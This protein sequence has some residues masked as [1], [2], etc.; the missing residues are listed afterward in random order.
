MNRTRLKTSDRVWP[1]LRSVFASGLL[2]LSSCHDVSEQNSGTETTET[3]GSFQSDT[4]S[5]ARARQQMVDRHLA[6]RDIHH[7]RVLEAMAR[8]P[9]HQFVPKALQAVAY[10]DSPL[11]IDAGQT[12]SQPYIVALMTQL[13]DPKADHKALD[14]GTGSG[15]QAA[16][17]SE[18]VDE[19][20]SIE[21]VESLADEARERLR[22]L[23]YENVTVRSGDGYAGWESEAPFDL[24]IV[25]AAPDHVPPALV[26]QLAVG[27]KLVIP[28]GDRVQNL[29]VIEKKPDG[30]IVKQEVAPVA[31]V[32]M[33]GA[34]QE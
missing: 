32:P 13:V 23:G 33:T 8:V 24:I 2:I 26:D 5:Y 17:L 15:Y 16:V 6:G 30:S 27:G 11:P 18:L 12:I 31:F 19:V 4:D 28:I 29:V 34:A 21:I 3:D 10:Q 7:V 9:R 14:V 1:G 25:A 22:G 20:F